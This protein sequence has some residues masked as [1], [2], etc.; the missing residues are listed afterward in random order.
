MSKVVTALNALNVSSRQLQS[1]S[2]RGSRPRPPPMASPLV[3]AA[4]F[5]PQTSSQLEH[6]TFAYRITPLCRWATAWSV[7]RWR[8]RSI[9]DY[10][11]RS[12]RDTLISAQFW[13]LRIC[14]RRRWKFFLISARS[15]VAWPIDWS[16]V[17]NNYIARPHTDWKQQTLEEPKEEEIT[18]LLLSC[19]CSSLWQ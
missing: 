18:S 17:H 2:F 1:F 6:P 19:T 15:I 10:C 4:G 14:V 8:M 11:A 12:H 5:S 13:R 9:A 16:T 3:S 7:Y